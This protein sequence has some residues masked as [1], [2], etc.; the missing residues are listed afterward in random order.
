MSSDL[1]V[2][3]HDSNFDKIIGWIETNIGGK[4][5]NVQRQAR[6]RP[7][8]FVDVD[9]GAGETLK[10]CVRGE[11]ADVPLVFPL[12]HEMLVQKLMYEHGIRVPK[13]YGWS[14]NPCCYIMERVEGVPHFEGV[15]LE[16]RRAVM[17][18]YMKL[19]ADLHKLPVQPFKDAGVLHAEN[20]AE[21]HLYGAQRFEQHIYRQ[22]KK[23]PDPFLEFVLGWIRRHPPKTACRE[24]LITW[25]SG[26]F[27]QQDGQLVAMI[28]VEL[29]HIG[30]PMM[31]LAAFRMR[32]T[33]LGFGDFNELYAWYEEFSGQ[34]VDMDAIKY[35]HLFFT[36]TNALSFH[37]ALAAP[38]LQSDYMT[39][40]QWV[41]ETN[42]FALEALAEYLDIDLPQIGMPAS[43]E[44]A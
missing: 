44:T 20:P 42:R 24:A 2:T 28:D 7:I 38:N 26:Q 3:L 27:H 23:R 14:D 41:N 13:V 31:D 4:V 17:R 6:W 10:L 35:H 25:D 37:T 29:G 8:Y 15:S 12:K 36:L 1:S 11:R 19:L 18:D 30:D 22:T 34:P 39:N 5:C 43:E 33:V 40:L 16:Q 21:A 32:D 9:M